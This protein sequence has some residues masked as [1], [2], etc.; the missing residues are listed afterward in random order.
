MEFACETNAADG[1][2]SKNWDTGLYFIRV[3]VGCTAITHGN[4][5]KYRFQPTEFLGTYV[6]LVG[7][8]QGINLTEPL[9]LL[10]SLTN[11]ELVEQLQLGRAV[12]LSLNKL[13]DRIQG[14]ARFLTKIP[15]YLINLVYGS[16]A[17]IVAIFGL[18]LTCTFLSEKRTDKCIRSLFA[19]SVR[20]NEGID[21]AAV[22]SMPPPPPPYRQAMP[23]V[24]RASSHNQIPRAVSAEAIKVLLADAD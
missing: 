14:S 2:Y 23:Y 7:I 5:V 8:P 16:L 20:F 15:T 17:L 3:K 24:S 21:D 1:S 10:S 4:N 9:S 18:M 6:S 22:H 13:K 19:P 12:K 11:P